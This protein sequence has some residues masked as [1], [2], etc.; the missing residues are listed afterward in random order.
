MSKTEK[1]K[2]GG[3][4]KIQCHS[5]DGNIPSGNARN[6]KKLYRNF[7]PRETRDLALLAHMNRQLG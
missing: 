6:G 3:E 1:V 4:K 7:T 2:Q 5:Y